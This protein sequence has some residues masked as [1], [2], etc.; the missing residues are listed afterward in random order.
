[1]DPLVFMGDVLGA[2]LNAEKTCLQMDFGDFCARCGVVWT[3]CLTRTA[4]KFKSLP[5]KIA[6]NFRHVK[7]FLKSAKEW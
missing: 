2:N 6:D 1:M 7:P 3:P 5:G 4:G